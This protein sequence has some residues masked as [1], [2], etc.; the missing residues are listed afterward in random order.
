MTGFDTVLAPAPRSVA[1]DAADMPRQLET[2]RYAHELVAGTRGRY[3][4]SLNRVSLNRVGESDG[5]EQVDL[6]MDNFRVVDLGAQAPRPTAPLPRP[7]GP[8][9]G[10]RP[11]ARCP[12]A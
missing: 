1:V 2:A 7:G 9:G 6:V 12:R 4:V 3:R 5:G 8:A 11:T 10:E